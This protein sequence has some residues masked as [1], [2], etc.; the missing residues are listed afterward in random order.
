MTQ[1]LT[2][3]IT[4]AANATYVSVGGEIDLANQAELERTLEALGADRRHVELDLRRVS[5]IDSSGLSM[6]LRMREHCERQGGVLVLDGLSPAV[7]RLFDV[8][9]ITA[10]FTI[11]S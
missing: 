9:G 8:V 10:L 5:F 1:A 2:L 11:I 6:L 7:R 3:E 4:S